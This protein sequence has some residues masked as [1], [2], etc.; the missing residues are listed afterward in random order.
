MKTCATINHGIEV[1]TSTLKNA[2]RG[3]F[4]TQKFEKGQWITKYEGSLIDQK[5]AIKLRKEKRAQFLA[6]CESQWTVVN[7]NTHVR[8]GFGGAQFANHEENKTKIN[9]K[10]V[11]YVDRKHPHSPW[12]YLRATRI[13]QPGE[14]IFCSYGKK[15]FLRDH[16][17][18]Y[19]FA[20]DSTTTVAHDVMKKPTTISSSRLTRSSTVR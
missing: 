4:A 13:I 3:L 7:G 1:K 18:P 8:S 9:A 19:D 20:M 15:A 2:G 11:I 10:L 6:T 17:H 12:P 16:I 14:E 5:Q